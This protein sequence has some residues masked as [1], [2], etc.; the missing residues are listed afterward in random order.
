CTELLSIETSIF[1]TKRLLSII[2]QNGMVQISGNT[3]TITK[4]R[5]ET[6]REYDEAELPELLKKYF[7]IEY[8]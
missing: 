5:I 6:Q 4:D 1:R 2:T 7:G 8:K 3:L